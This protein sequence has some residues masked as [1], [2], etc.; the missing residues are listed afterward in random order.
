MGRFDVRRLR[1]AV[2]T[3]ALAGAALVSPTVAAPD[4]PPPVETSEAPAVDPVAEEPPGPSDH[5]PSEPAD[6][7]AVVVAASADLLIGDAAVIEMVIVEPDTETPS[8]PAAEPIGPVDVNSEH[9]EGHG[10]SGTHSGSG[11]DG[12]PYLMTFEVVWSDPDGR[13]VGVL[14]AVL[15]DGWRSSFELSA[16]SETGRGMPTSATCAYPDGSDVLQCVFDNPGHREASD[17]LVVPAR[18]TATYQVAVAWPATDH[19]TIDGVGDSYSPRDLC[20]R[21]GHDSGGGHDVPVGG[22]EVVEGQQGHGGQGGQG[23][24]GGQGGQGGD[25][26]DQVRTWTC[27]HTVV[28]RQMAVVV[29]RP[30]PPAVE[31]VVPQEPAVP[32]APAVI[33]EPTVPDSATAESPVET[34]AV[35]VTTRSLPA[36]GNTVPVLLLLAGLLVAAGSTAVRLARPTSGPDQ[37]EGST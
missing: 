24:D 33:D 22:P 35:V 27:V 25:G 12:N 26:G 4:E 11:G 1:L 9:E 34:A 3:G 32:V 23:G 7:E 14:D 21:G 17:G 31:P 37:I 18:Q 5:D 36:T 19:W 10:G 20:P 28:M 30:E 16:D 8:V 15:A 2:V 13:P 6:P 29:P